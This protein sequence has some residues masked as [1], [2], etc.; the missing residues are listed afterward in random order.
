[1]GLEIKY[2]KG[3]TPLS[4]EEMEGLLI[5]SI[6]THGELD[7]F[8]Q[9]N[10]QKAI[11]HYLFGRKIKADK[12]LTEDF[13]LNAHTKMLNEVWAWA[14][15]FR[16]S[17]KNIG[18][19]WHQVPIEL[20]QLI[21]D[22]KFWIDNETYPPEEIAIRFKHRLVAIHVFPN[23]NGRHSRLMGDV[24]MKHVFGK[25][26]FTWGRNNLVDKGKTRDKYIDSLQKADNGNF[27]ELIAFAQS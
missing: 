18:G 23:G 9:L 16:K 26:I 14:G 22:C 19:P 27:E 7:E 2:E 4:E 13:I 12:I 1:M 24:L 20:K 6:T 10:I 17:D 21:D 11:E 8:E 5:P 15:E 3:Q 25:P